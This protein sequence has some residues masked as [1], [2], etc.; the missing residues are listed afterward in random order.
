MRRQAD[1]PTKTKVISSL[2]SELPHNDLFSY[3]NITP[4]LPIV[5]QPESNKRFT[6]RERVR[7]GNKL[8]ARDIQLLEVS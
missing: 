6:Q 2:V 7:Q 8:T 5:G 3:P 4:F 1:Q